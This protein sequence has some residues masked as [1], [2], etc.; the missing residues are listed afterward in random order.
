MRRKNIKPV[1]LR[2]RPAKLAPSGLAPPPTLGRP[3]RHIFPMS[4][5]IGYFP[6]PLP[7][8][9]V[10]S[11]RGKSLGWSCG[12]A[13]M[14]PRSNPS[15]PPGMPSFAPF[16]TRAPIDPVI[17]ARAASS[18]YKVR[19][20]RLVQS[21]G[22]TTRCKK[23]KAHSLWCDCSERKIWCRSPKKKNQFMSEVPSHAKG[24]NSTHNSVRAASCS[25]CLV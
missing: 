17:L 20:G 14:A 2:C 24:A 9:S 3:R 4:S 21:V 7:E 10:E 19:A 23:R 5:S 13:S 1:T 12:Q 6:V 18:P 15:M 8:G 25:R 11:V 22:S 16:F